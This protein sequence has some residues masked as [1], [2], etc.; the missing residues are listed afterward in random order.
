M[1]CP[2][3]KTAFSWKTGK[4]VTGVIHNPHY[5]Q[6]QQ[7]LNNL[8]RQPGDI[9]CG[10]LPDRNMYSNKLNQILPK[11]THKGKLYMNN[12]SHFLYALLMFTTHI[13]N[14]EMR[15][16]PDLNGFSTH[17]RDRINYI[18]GD[19]EEKSFKKSLIQK[20]KQHLK[21]K[22]YNDI[23]E[24]CSTL[25]EEITRKVVSDKVNNEEDLNKVYEEVI[26]IIKYVIIL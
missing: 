10:G 4:I 24:T 16:L 7:M 15:D 14:V 3:C 25:L 20:E 11:I 21:T 13:R 23:Y 1:Y 8:R 22:E 17:L 26:L 9:P 18:L 19:V 5:F 6:D 12:L 2:P